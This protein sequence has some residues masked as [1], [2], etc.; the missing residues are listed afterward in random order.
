ML[1]QEPGSPKSK[2]EPCLHKELSG[3]VALLAG[4]HSGQSVNFQCESLHKSNKFCIVDCC[5]GRIGGRIFRL[6]TLLTWSLGKRRRASRGQPGQ[7]SPWLYAHL[8]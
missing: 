1:V 2:G 7:I 6:A 4:N 8:T 3:L 5:R